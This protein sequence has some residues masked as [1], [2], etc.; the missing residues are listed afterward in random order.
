MNPDALNPPSKGKR[1][2]EHHLAQG[3]QRLAQNEE[4][5]R[6]L[7]E[8]A[9]IESRF[10]LYRKSFTPQALADDSLPPPRT[11]HDIGRLAADEARF[12]LVGEAGAGKTANLRRL[13]QT[14]LKAYQANPTTAPVPLWLDLGHGDNPV[15]THDLISRHW[16][17]QYSHDLNWQDYRG[18][19]WLFLDGLDEMPPPANE[20]A[21]RLA[22][23]RRFIQATDGLHVTA[24][25]RLATYDEAL[26]LN[27]PVAHLLPLDDERI[28]A[29]IHQRLLRDDLW[30]KMKQRPRLRGMA[31]TPFKLVM[32]VSVYQHQKETPDNSHD[33]YQRFISDRLGGNSSGPLEPPARQEILWRKL[34]RLAYRMSERNKGTAADREWVKRQI[35]RR[36]LQAA[37]GLNILVREQ[38][39]VRFLHP[40]MQRYFALPGMIAALQNRF[41]R[42]ERAAFLL[43]EIASMGEAALPAVPALVYSLQSVYSDVRSEASRALSAVGEKAVPALTHVLGDTDWV[44][45]G[46]AANILGNIG[47]GANAAVPALR[48]ALN[49]EEIAVRLSVATALTKIGHGNLAMP[50]VAQ[51]ARDP[52][53]YIRGAAAA[54]TGRMQASVSGAVPLL[55]DLLADDSED[56]RQEAILALGK[57]G[58]AAVNEL[59]EMLRA[60]YWAERS[61]LAG[62]TG[63]LT[64]L[65]EAAVPA[66]VARAEKERVLVTVGVRKAL[67]SIQ[68]RPPAGNSQSTG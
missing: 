23:L 36:D 32:L 4:Q 38:S 40:S 5:L 61:T 57:L 65:P 48:R 37:L 12:V 53:A 21:A 63:A 19:L 41:I 45:R 17:I 47:P 68:S 9:L 46:E 22:A 51:A 3:L 16:T 28:R 52:R 7:S 14:A 67:A 54:I 35:G 25:A 58:Q 50:A 6:N 2:L 24:A 20:A 43:R 11:Y 59:R 55:L 39:A 1:S 31:R 26:S 8:Q 33:L 49:D 42:P 30:E 29:Y 34:Q 56:V 10:A 60:S 13:M 66:L 15:N 44:V 27:L 62:M 18:R 64:D